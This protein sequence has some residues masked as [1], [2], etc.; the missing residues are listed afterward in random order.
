MSSDISHAVRN[1]RD[2]RVSAPVSNCLVLPGQGGDGIALRVLAHNLDELAQFALANHLAGKLDHRVTGVVVS[3]SK[4]LLGLVDDLAQ[5]ASLLEIECDGLVADHVETGFQK[6]LG[7][8]E[9]KKVLHNDGNEINSFV[10]GKGFLLFS[11]LLGQ[12]HTCQ[13]RMGI[14]YPWNS[15]IINPPCKT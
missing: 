7:N 5:L 1:S 3:E 8:F 2:L 4:N 12:S 15:I 11:H 6:G 9:M 10:F 14:H 13:F